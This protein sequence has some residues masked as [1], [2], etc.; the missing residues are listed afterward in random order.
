M[1][2]SGG[3]RKPK[4]YWCW[5]AACGL[6]RKGG[7]TCE[8]CGSK[9]HVRDISLVAVVRAEV[10]KRGWEA[11]VKDEKLWETTKQAMEARAQAMSREVARKEAMAKSWEGSGTGKDSDKG[12]GFLEGLLVVIGFFCVFAFLF[13]LLFAPKDKGAWDCD[14]RPIEERL[15]ERDAKRKRQESLEN[16]ERQAK[17]LDY[18]RKYGPK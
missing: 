14:G 1:E 6:Q 15:Y 8:R 16:L 12:G 13:W 3:E 7:N 10:D 2:S 5:C 11:V 9:M 17:E 4:T 18:R